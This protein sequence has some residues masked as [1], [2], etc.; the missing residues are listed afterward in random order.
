MTPDEA[1]E[2]ALRRIRKA[3]ETGAVELDLSGRWTTGRLS[4]SSV[5]RSQRTEPT[6]ISVAQSWW[7]PPARAKVLRCSQTQSKRYDLHSDRGADG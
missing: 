4:L 3:K 1:Y 2:E 7:T 6:I 5:H